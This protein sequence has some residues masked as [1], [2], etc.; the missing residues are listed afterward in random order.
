MSMMYVWIDWKFKMVPAPTRAMPMSGAI[1]WTSARAVQPVMSRPAGSKNAPGT[2]DAAAFCQF[3]A[4]P[5][6]EG[7]IRT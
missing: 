1:Q 3:P 2:I 6:K 5:W 7:G 4:E